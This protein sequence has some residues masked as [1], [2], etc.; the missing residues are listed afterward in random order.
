MQ[1]KHGAIV[2]SAA[3]NGRLP[4]QS[5]ALLC[6]KTI[7]AIG[8][9]VTTFG[10]DVWLYQ[11]TGSYQIFVLLLVL[12]GLPRLLLSTV[13]GVLADVRHKGRILLGCE[14]V[15]L[16][17]IASAALLQWIGMLSVGAVAAVVL[18]L[19]LSETFRWPTF[20]ATIARLTPASHLARING[21]AET[22]RSATILA[23]PV[24][25]LA[26]LRTVGLL[27]MLSFNAMTFA[28]VGTLLVVFGITVN[29]TLR[30]APKQSIT[31]GWKWDALS[32]GF[33][34]IAA[35]R[36]FRQLLLLFACAN[37]A[38][39]ILVAVQAPYIL[40]FSGPEILSGALVLDGL[41]LLVGGFLFYRMSRYWHLG[42]LILLAVALEA[43]A[44]L[45]LG[46]SRNDFMV[47]A[48]AFVV[49]L[50][51]STGNAASQTLWQSNVPA[52][53]QGRV[54][55]VR[56]LVA[57]CASPIALLLSI[58]LAEHVFKPLVHPDAA[59][60]LIPSVW[61]SGQTGAIGLML[62]CLGAPILV[63]AIGGHMRGGLVIG[64]RAAESPANNNTAPVTGT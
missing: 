38:F 61:G 63:I 28:T 7:S 34:W 32:F 17:A 20:T 46:A 35:H 5:M 18:T 53:I 59:L 39:S 16:A 22:L 6:G 55:A 56:A 47:L 13:A 26:A 36:G 24:I 11:K 43:T 44:M 25:G 37:C 3:S 12:T 23:G 4:R 31:A 33:R 60:A 19:S 8:T 30:I 45:V 40:S 52:E 58:P 64:G 48:C 10:L 54:F 57:S 50:C 9:S 1:K 27:G 62:S 49:S 21:I 29:P 41:G 2:N 51:G 15:S 14:L 42:R